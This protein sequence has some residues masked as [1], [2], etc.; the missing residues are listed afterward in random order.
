MILSEHFQADAWWSIQR[1]DNVDFAGLPVALEGDRTIADLYEQGTFVGQITLPMP[2][3]HNLSN[4]IGALAACRMEGVPL[5]RLI[6]HLSEL[7]TPGRRF[8]YRGDWQGRQIDVNRN[9]RHRKFRGWKEHRWKPSTCEPWIRNW[10]CTGVIN[11]SGSTKRCRLR[12][13]RSMN[14]KSEQHRMITS[15]IRL[16]PDA[17][18]LMGFS[19]AA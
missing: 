6:S 12:K 4:T 1:S 19:T 17:A 5:E 2:G 7:K 9:H 14:G 8:D 3:L 10:Q 13:K 18:R 11:G 15:E 16:P